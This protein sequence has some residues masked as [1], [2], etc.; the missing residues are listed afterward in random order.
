VKAKSHVRP[1]V[2]RASESDSVT[3]APKPVFS[4]AHASPPSFDT[5][6]PTSVPR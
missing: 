4:T 1:A 3:I 2:S 5:K 6:T